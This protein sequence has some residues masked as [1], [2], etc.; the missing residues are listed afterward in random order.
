MVG[1]LHSSHISLGQAGRLKPT[2]RNGFPIFRSKNI[3]EDVAFFP[4]CRL[5]SSYWFDIYTKSYLDAK[6][7]EPVSVA[8]DMLRNL[9]DARRQHLIANLQ[10]KIFTSHFAF[11]MNFWTK[12]ER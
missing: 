12:G 2:V 6:L 1:K 4:F 8:T 5:L 3:T 11:N 9:K 10:R 7:A